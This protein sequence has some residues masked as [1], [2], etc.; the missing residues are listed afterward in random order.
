MRGLA[1]VTLILGL[2]RMAV[3][4]VLEPLDDACMCS[5]L[6]WLLRDST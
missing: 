3:I 2:N 4:V 6:Y 1:H 5:T